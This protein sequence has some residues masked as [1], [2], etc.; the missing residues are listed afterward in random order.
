MDL[1]LTQQLSKKKPMTN[2]NVKGLLLSESSCWD[3]THFFNINKA[4]KKPDGQDQA[5]SN[6]TL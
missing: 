3:F 5:F 2:P 1:N 6:S 4:L